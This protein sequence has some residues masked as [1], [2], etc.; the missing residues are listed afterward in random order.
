LEKNN[1]RFYSII[2]RVILR[3]AVTDIRKML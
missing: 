2:S 3:T 1:S